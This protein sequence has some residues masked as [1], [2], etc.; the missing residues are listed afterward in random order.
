MLRTPVLVPQVAGA[1]TATVERDMQGFGAFLIDLLLDR[2]IVERGI[3]DW[4]DAERVVRG[5]IVD[6]SR[7]PELVKH[8]IRTTDD[9]VG[10]RRLLSLC[11]R[12]AAGRVTSL[13]ELG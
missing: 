1:Q 4:Y 3:V 12:L 5:G 8:L 6:C 10:W 7:R 11:E 2:P 13:A 9:P